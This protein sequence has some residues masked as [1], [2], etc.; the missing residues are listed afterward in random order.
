M[1]KG[2]LMPKPKTFKDIHTLVNTLKNKKLALSVWFNKNTYSDIDKMVRDSVSANTFRAFAHTPKPPSDI[3]RLWAINLLSQKTFINNIRTISSQDSFNKWQFNFACSFEI[4]WNNK[5]GK[6][7]SIP[8]GA[9][10]KLPNLLLKH[11]VRWDALSKYDRHKLIGFL[12]IPYDSYSLLALKKTVVGINIPANATMH[13]VDNI[14]LYNLL[15]I[16]S[17]LIASFANVPPIYIDILAYNEV[18]NI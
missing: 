2:D 6:R 18:H 8:F 14:A 3:F 17:K 7:Y 5:M 16:Q 11:I 9:S 13:F 12:H 4:Y 15:T 1:K 10:R